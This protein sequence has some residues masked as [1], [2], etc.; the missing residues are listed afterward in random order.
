MTPIP[1]NIDNLRKAAPAGRFG[2]FRF[3]TAHFLASL[4]LLFIGLPFVML[5]KHGDLIESLLMTLVMFMGVLSAGG[6]KKSLI[7][8]IILVM[9]ALA[10]KW[11]NHYRPDLLPQSVFQLAM[12]VFFL[13]L[14][15]HLLRYI[16]KAPRVNSEVLCAAIAIYLLL[17]LLWTSAY[18]LMAQI[19]PDSFAFNA[20]PSASQTMD[21]STA[22]Y[23]SYVTLCT[24]GF[25]DVTPVSNA[26]RMLAIL[27]AMTGTFYMAILI[28]RLVSLYSFKN[29][30]DPAAKSARPPIE[31][32]TQSIENQKPFNG[33]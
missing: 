30:F 11:I 27:E 24:V 28:A 17:G 29:P 1:E 32:E 2:V 13:F 3:S 14:V 33:N 22:F 18:L 31:K 7:I 15:G 26:A 4:V 9:P 23:F 20:G 19:A 10:G 12:L 5:F 25:G 16:F 6:R 8:A 21:A